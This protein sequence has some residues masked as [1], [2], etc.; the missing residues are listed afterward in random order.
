MSTARGFTDLRIYDILER[1]EHKE[2]LRPVY[3]PITPLSSPWP[4]TCSSSFLI[5]VLVP[6]VSGQGKRRAARH[7]LPF[8]PLY[9]AASFLGLRTKSRLLHSLRHV[10][11]FPIICIARSLPGNRR[12]RSGFLDHS[13]PSQAVQPSCFPADLFL[14]VVAFQTHGWFHVGGLT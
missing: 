14:L 3:L 6:H 4:T 8:S 12:A 5:P 9:L 7:P 1:S 2:I 11:C 10:T 13:C